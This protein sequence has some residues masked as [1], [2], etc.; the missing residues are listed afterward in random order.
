[1]DEKR[2]WSKSPKLYCESGKMTI[3]E[4]INGRGA[5]W[6]SFYVNKNS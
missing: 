1:M 2:F 5:E 4:E 6:T 3:P